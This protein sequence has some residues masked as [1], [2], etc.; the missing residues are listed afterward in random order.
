[1]A[2]FFDLSCNYSLFAIPISWTLA[3]AP[4]VYATQLYQRA[5]S[6]QFDNR[7]PRTLTK[8][9]AESQ[10]IDSTTKGRIIRAEMAQQNGFENVGLFAAAVVAG[11]MAQL[12][13]TWLNVLSFG[14]VI[15]RVI[16][17]IVYVHNTTA[18]LAA[19][20]TMVFTSGAGMIWTL[21]IMAGNK[22]RV[23]S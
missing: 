23:S 11:N 20:R 9:V 19:T 12:D 15:S 8:I 4:H 22:L 18:A 7:Q 3:L 21:F 1:M 13:H 17:N 2:S 5:S 6:R 10:T 16:Y 14:Y